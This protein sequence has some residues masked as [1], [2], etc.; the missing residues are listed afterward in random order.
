[1]QRARRRSRSRSWRAGRRCRSRAGLLVQ[2]DP[3]SSE[4]RWRS[5]SRACAERHRL[6]PHAARPTD[7]GLRGETHD[8]GVLESP[9][10]PHA[11]SLYCL[12]GL[13]R[14]PNRTEG[15][16]PAALANRS[17]RKGGKGSRFTDEAWR[18]RLRLTRAGVST[19]GEGRFLCGILPG[20]IWQ[21]LDDKCVYL[22]AWTWVRSGNHQRPHAACAGHPTDVVY[23]TRAAILTPGPNDHRVA[24]KPAGPVLEP[25]NASRAASKETPTER[26]AP[27]P[28]FARSRRGP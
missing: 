11:R 12:R 24:R 7:T 23:R 8:L 5:G 3:T 28:P 27:S 17:T 2:Q 22:R 20:R 18:D 16:R 10:H 19:D 26:S 9:R 21:S 6:W 15:G 14:L 1:M 25:R 4:P 13:R